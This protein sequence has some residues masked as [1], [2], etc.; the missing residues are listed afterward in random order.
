VRY[1]KGASRYTSE[2]NITAIIGDDHHGGQINNTALNNTE[3]AKENAEP[4][5]IYYSVKFPWPLSNR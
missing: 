1:R 5:S 3:I 2:E 4:E